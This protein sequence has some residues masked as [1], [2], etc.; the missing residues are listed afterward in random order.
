ML[1]APKSGFGTLQN[2]THALCP[3][4]TRIAGTGAALETEGRQVTGE[5]T[6]RPTGVDVLA[7]RA[8]GTL[9]CTILGELARTTQHAGHGRRLLS[10]CACHT[11]ADVGRPCG[12]GEWLIT[13]A[14]HAGTLRDDVVVFAECF[15]EWFWR[16]Y[17]HALIYF[18]VEHVRHAT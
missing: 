15:F 17:E 12:F 18:Y 16:M 11:I 14:R 1:L 13:V 10:R 9:S 5:A 6:F 4:R 3:N 2:A 7:S 8:F